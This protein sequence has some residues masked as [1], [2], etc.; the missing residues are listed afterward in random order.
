MRFDGPVP[1]HTLHRVTPTLKVDYYI[2]PVD[3]DQ[4]TPNKFYKL[5]KA[6]ES[7]FVRQLKTG[8]EQEQ[9]TRQRMMNEAQGWFMPDAVKMSQARNMVMKNCRKLE[10]L[11]QLG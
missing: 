6:A 1:P 11:A 7:N 3:V 5:D 8:C 2:N 10:E 4:F 9:E